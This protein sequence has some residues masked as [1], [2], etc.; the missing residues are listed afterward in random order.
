MEEMW[1]AIF[2]HP[3]Q[4]CCEPQIDKEVRVKLLRVFTNS[5]PFNILAFKMI[6]EHFFFLVHGDHDD[7]LCLRTAAQYGLS[8][9]VSFLASLPQ[10][11]VNAVNRSALSVC[12]IYGKLAPCR[13][14]TTCPRVDVNKPNN[15]GATPLFIACMHGELLIV[16]ELLGRSD[17]DVNFAD[18]E[19]RSPLARAICSA[20]DPDHV[21]HG[22]ENSV[23]VK[24][25]AYECAKLLIARPDVDINH[26]VEISERMVNAFLLAKDLQ[27]TELCQLIHARLDSKVYFYRKDETGIRTAALS[28]SPQEKADLLAKEAET[29]KSF[30]ETHFAEFL[31]HAKTILSEEE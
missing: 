12:A 29:G 6:N 27:P 22:V 23:A 13:I 16:Q 30:Q 17:I 1:R 2:D 19:S 26:G 5:P 28:L 15:A 3:I 25:R 10:V 21:V 24:K 11:D 31:D 9:V 8:D 4:A 7:D 14:L 18:E 20:G